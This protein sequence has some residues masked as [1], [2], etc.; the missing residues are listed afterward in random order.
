[1]AVG[2]DFLKHPE[3]DSNMSMR[4]TNEFVPAVYFNRLYRW[5]WLV[6]VLAVAGGVVGLVVHRFKPPQYETEAV[7][8]ASID[9]NKIDFMHPPEGTPAPYHFTDADED[10]SLAMVEASLRWVMPQVVTFAN[11]QGLALDEASLKEHAIIER[12]HAFWYLRFRGDDPAIVQAVTNFWAEAGFTNLKDWQ[13]TGK[14]PVYI[15]FDLIQKADLPKAPTFFHTNTFV[16]AGAVIGLVAGM[17][18][19]NLPFFKSGQ[20]S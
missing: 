10:L 17:L 8:L 14:V 20:E 4:T 7:F 6:F 3:R 12:H 15:F 16:L 5:W 2:P 11:Q 19:V 18:L 1:M 9:F 13:L